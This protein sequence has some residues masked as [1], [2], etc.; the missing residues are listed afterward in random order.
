MCLR[1]AEEAAVA[2]EVARQVVRQR[3]DILVL[4][5]RTLHIG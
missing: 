1:L 5:E 2:L 4:A 3:V